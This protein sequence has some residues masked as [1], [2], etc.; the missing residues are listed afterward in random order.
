MGTVLTLDECP[1]ELEIP[2]ESAVVIC[3]ENSHQSGEQASSGR[4]ERGEDELKALVVV[5]G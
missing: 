4:S 3:L 5:F 2:V 1:P